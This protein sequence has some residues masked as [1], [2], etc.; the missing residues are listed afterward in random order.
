V[1][2]LAGCLALALGLLRSLTSL[3]IVEAPATPPSASLTG[4][5]V[6]D[7]SIVLP[8]LLSRRVS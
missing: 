2:L 3:A 7:T 6:S 4:E 5:T 1:R 8:A